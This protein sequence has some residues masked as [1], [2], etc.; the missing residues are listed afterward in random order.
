VY[1]SLLLALTLAVPTEAGKDARWPE[2]RGGAASGVVEDNNL[3]DTWSTTKNVVW[4]TE[5]PGIGWSSPVVWGDRIYVTTVRRE[6]KGEAPKKG[7]Y[8]GGERGKPKDVHHWLVYCLDW[9]SGKVLWEREVHKGVP[10]T[11]LH[12][13]NSYASET[14]VTD[15][16]RVY[17]YF[18]NVGLFCLDRDGKEVWHQKWDVVPTAFGWGTAASPT[19]YKDRLYLVNDNNK[20]SFLVALDKQTGK[21]VWR[22]ERDEKSNWATPFI[23]E[24]EKRT[25]IITC[26]KKVRSYDLDG[27]VLWE[28]TGMSTIVIPTPLTGHGLLYISSGYVGYPHKPVY[29]IRPGATG[30]ISLKEGT[31]SNAFIAWYQKNAGPYNPSPLLYGDYFYVLYDFGMFGCY[32]AKTGKMIYDRVRMGPGAKA[33]TA[34]PWA[35][36][37]KIFCLSE[38]GDT[39]VIKA[40]TK[41]TLLG[42][43]SLDEMCLAT[44]AIARGSLIIRTQS[45]VYRIEKRETAGR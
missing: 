42:K 25:E 43:N 35:Y 16:E 40:G 27:K 1:A 33:F 38:D 32:E 13:K 8:F 31:T 18:G 37:G 2:F 29:A 21:Q 17:A 28:L 7:L 11:G 22:V 41:Y 14:P 26:G 44:P 4:K 3:P 20:Q 30:D 10:E 5:I 39:F 36:Q 24:N 23:W 6:G 15:G 34:S 45:K 19:L 9:Q 12:V